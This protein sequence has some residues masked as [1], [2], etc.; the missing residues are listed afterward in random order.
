MSAQPETKCADKVAAALESRLEDLRIIWPAYQAGQEVPED[1]GLGPWD[2]YALAFDYVEAGTFS[3]QGSGY[4][5]YQISTGGPGEEVRFYSDAALS[6]DRIEFW[7][8]DWY[9]D[10]HVEPAGADGE[11]LAE[12]WEFFV[13]VGTVQYLLDQAE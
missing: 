13:E 2:E 11:L 7:Y 12:I 9:D 1:T 10:A 8:L 6:L 5:R 4:F 3:G